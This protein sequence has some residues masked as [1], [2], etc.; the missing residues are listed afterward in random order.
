[1]LRRLKAGFRGVEV[2]EAGEGLTQL[3]RRVDSEEP[4]L[5]PGIDSY[6]DI[7]LGCVLVRA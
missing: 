3:Q 4:G 1:L 6:P 7:L 5:E 2:K